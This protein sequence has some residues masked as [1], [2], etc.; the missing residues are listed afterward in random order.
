[1]TKMGS[2]RT[3]ASPI[4]I[5]QEI[6]E[7]AENSDI[8][9]ASLAALLDQF[10]SAQK[11]KL[12]KL[13]TSAV[14]AQKEFSDIQKALREAQEARLHAERERDDTRLALARS[15]SDH[16]S[17]QAELQ[18][19]QTNYGNI[20]RRIRHAA[21]A[22]SVIVAAGLTTWLSGAHAFFLAAH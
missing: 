6:S 11:D 5:L 17:S 2:D 18:Q 21:I 4:A 7:I 1:M 3:T 9:L 20:K 10:G 12:S 13:K 14:S 19:T 8:Q 15:Q 16:Q 22:A